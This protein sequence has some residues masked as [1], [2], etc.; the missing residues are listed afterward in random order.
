LPDKLETLAMLLILL[1]GLTCAYIV[2][3]LAVRKKQ[4]ELDKIVE[5]LI[6]SFIFYILTLPFFGY[7]LPAYWQESSGHQFTIVPNWP[8]LLTL[9]IIAVITALLYSANLN[10]DWLLGL[11]RNIRLTDRTA[12]SSIWNDVFQDVRGRYLE[13]GLS[14]GRVVIGYLRYYSD[15]ATDASLFLEDAAWKDE[16][17]NQIPIDGPGILLTKRSGIT[18]INF[19]NP[20]HP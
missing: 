4:T 2:Q 11:F 12:R 1:P 3:H 16:D 6:F 5:A 17:G 14:D 10:H 19:L 20:Q 9:A 18:F 15:E 8:Y 13:V 7:S